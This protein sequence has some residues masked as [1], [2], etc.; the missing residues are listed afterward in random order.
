MKLAAIAAGFLALLPAGK[1][2]AQSNR[3]LTDS[4]SGTLPA[5][6]SAASAPA[7]SGGG[8]AAIPDDDGSMP[9]DVNL[10][11]EKILLLR[12]TI[13]ALTES[14]AVANSEGEAFKR[15]TADMALKLDA[16]GLVS[17]DKDPSKLEQK[18]LAAVRDLR[19]MKEQQEAAI[20]ELLR[21]SEAVQ[22]LMKTSDSA[23]PQL[24]MAVETELRKTSAILGA[25]DTAKPDAVEATLNDAMVVDL[26]D[27]L[28]LVVANIGEKQGVQVGMPFQV[29]RKDKQIGEVR[30]VD[31][32]DR[33]CG[34]IIQSL[35][36]EKVP[37]KTGDRLKVDARP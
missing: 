35:E 27:D 8:S 3:S 32:R 17:T 15:Q 9:N 11:Q 2:E 37:I 26:K 14:L 13:K 4:D 6:E 31:V 30:V 16:L 20:T 36:S 23:D 12:S 28:S 33:I 1:L 29:W 22:V 24:R 18:L 25:P 7:T 10:L 5:P 19:V 21:L 34:A